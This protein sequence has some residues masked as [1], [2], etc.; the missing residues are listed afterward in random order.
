MSTEKQQSA[1]DAGRDPSDPSGGSPTEATGNGSANVPPSLGEPIVAAA[2]AEPKPPVAD[3]VVHVSADE[4]VVV[5]HGAMPDAGPSIPDKLKTL[6]IGK[7]RDLADKSVF[8]HISLVAFLAWVGLGADGLSSSCYGPPEAF[9]ALQGHT[10]LGVFLAIAIMG[11]VWII[12]TCYGH[13]IEE[14]PS[15]GGGYLVASKLLGNRVGV[16]SGCAL[17]VDYVL[18]IS[19]SISAAGDAI[20]GLLAPPNSAD[21]PVFANVPFLSLSHLNWG[22]LQ[23]YA[24]CGVIFALMILNLRGVKESIQLLLPIFIVFL[25]THALV[26]VGSIVLHLPS[27]GAV[28][29]EKSREFAGGWSDPKFGMLGM[30]L[31]LLR[32]Y[33]L[34]AGTYTGLEAVSNSMTVLREPRVATARRTMRYMAISLSLVAGGLIIAYLL[35]GINHSLLPTM[36]QLLTEKLLQDVGLGGTWF[37][38]LFVWI[39]LLSAGALLVVGAQAGF[40][41]GPRVL[42]NMAHDSWV[43]RWFAH[44]S[45]RLSQ[46]NG[47]ILMGLLALGAVLYTHGNIQTLVVMYSINVFLTFSLSMIGMCRHWIEL[48][49][50]NPLWRRRL[51][52]FLMGAV[53]CLS[54][55]VVSIVEKFTSGGWLTVGVTLVCVVLCFAI[56]HYYNKVGERLR[57]LDESL[58]RL[59]PTGEP[60]NE[61]PDPSQP[62]AV[63]L[64]GNYSG[65]GIHTMLSAIR[66]APDHFRSFIFISTGVI[67]S[68]VFKGS[69]AME[70]LQEHIASSLEQYVDLARRLGMPATSYM[71][72]G[73]DAVDEL[74]ELCLEVVQDFPKATF[75]AGQLVFQKDNWVHRLLHNQTAYSLQRR[76]QWAGYPMVILPTRVR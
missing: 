76:L 12:A 51:A 24:V 33:S 36:N 49:K 53:L 65:L 59:T 44:L 63:I 23:L 70:S 16:I 39:T 9:G 37:S 54:I 6:I 27:I 66:F 75:F 10:Y 30:L 57:K 13:I 29:A 42:A 74:E 22:T 5:E 60:T 28:A 52:L 11:T 18:T 62:A 14:F 17:V 45:E 64:V 47:I 50:E 69:G 55:L 68:G 48:R 20:F 25:I 40:I 21:L 72:V 61:A 4:G 19:V 35:L 56:H 32:A 31:V 34:G 38:K 67:D 73:T 58:G 3:H 7:P 1:I 2:S 43:P 46:Q 8:T 26:I 71:R 15:G 41:D